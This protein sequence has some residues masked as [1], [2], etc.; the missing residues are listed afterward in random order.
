MS[1]GRIHVANR[2]VVEGHDRDVPRNCQPGVHQGL[3]GAEGE[4]V[5][6]TDQL[7][8]PRAP[9]Q[10]PGCF[11]PVLWLPIRAD[12]AT[13]DRDAGRAE[14]FA[15]AGESLDTCERIGRYVVDAGSGADRMD[16]A[17][18]SGI[19][20]AGSSAR[21]ETVEEQVREHARHLVRGR[22]SPWPPPHRQVM[23]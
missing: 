2:V 13:G 8:R 1:A 3:V 7:G 17:P 16:A 10:F 12:A 23:H 11:M 19:S 21:V 18:V 22:P 9:K 6:E 20:R 4:A 5:V 15:D 14:D